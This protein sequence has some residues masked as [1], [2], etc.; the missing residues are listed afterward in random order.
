[1]QD[2]V[3]ALEYPHV[4]LILEEISEIYR[5]VSARRI[6]LNT[7]IS[8]LTFQVIGLTYRI[9][10]NNEPSQTL[11]QT[12]GKEIQAI[13]IKSEE[14]PS[15][16]DVSAETEMEIA[17]ESREEDREVGVFTL[18]GEDG[19]EEDSIL[20]FDG[21]LQPTGEEKQAAEISKKIAKPIPDNLKML[22][23]DDELANRLLLKAIMTPYGDIDFANDGEQA[24][25]AFKNGYENGLPYDV[26][27]LDIMMPHMDGQT[28][29]KIIRRIERERRVGPGKDVNIFMVSCLDD[30][31][32]LEAFFR[33]Q[34]TDYIKKPYT[35]NYLLD[36]MREYALIR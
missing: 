36:K 22:I 26:I 13:L 19:D 12:L 32:V 34:C 24:V 33:G 11:L 17:I 2:V 7:K 10:I 1:M 14:E 21:P 20:F 9:V 6:I 4:V 30:E 31:N 3:S 28:A 27:F 16:H 25:E 18:F 15:Q 5:A 23:V 35:A 29:L 8:D